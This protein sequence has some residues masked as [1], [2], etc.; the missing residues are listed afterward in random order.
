MIAR[1]HKAVS[2]TMSIA[3]GKRGKSFITERNTP[4]HVKKS[5]KNMNRVCV[6]IL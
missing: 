2:A 6:S 3:E 5:R 4:V 1:K